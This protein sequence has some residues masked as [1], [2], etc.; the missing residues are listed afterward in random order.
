MPAATW[1]SATTARTSSTAA[2]AATRT[3]A[4]RQ[5]DLADFCPLVG[6]QPDLTARGTADRWL[7]YVFGGKGGTDPSRPEP[8]VRLSRLRAPRYCG[9][10]HAQPMDGRRPGWHDPRSVHVF[11]VTMRDQANPLVHQDHQG[12][13]WLYGGW[14]RDVMQGDV[15]GNGP[16]PGDRLIDWTGAYNLYTHCNSAYG[17]YNDIRQFSPAMQNSCS[18]LRG[19]RA[20]VRL[21]RTPPPA[22]SAFDEPPR[23]TV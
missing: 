2:R 21:R 10:V 23:S 11:L 19:A 13:D 5:P 3:R 20:R 16:N 17:G 12:T 18:S 9:I 14:D 1:C 4:R 8:W 22:A 7:D 6:G 15:A